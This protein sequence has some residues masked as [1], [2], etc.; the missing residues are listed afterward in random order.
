MLPNSA[1]YKIKMYSKVLSLQLSTFPIPSK[2]LV[3]K[4]AQIVHISGTRRIVFMGSESKVVSACT[5]HR[6]STGSPVTQGAPAI[7]KRRV[8]RPCLRPD[9]TTMMPPT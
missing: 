3:F 4:R 9:A 5:T 8:H 2:I 1:H 7:V 6:P